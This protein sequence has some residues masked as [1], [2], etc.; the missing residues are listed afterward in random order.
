[1]KRHS[2]I[3]RENWRQRVEQIGFSFHTLDGVTYWDESAYYEFTRAEADKIEQ[4]TNEIYQLCLHAVDHVVKKGLYDLFLIPHPF[5]DKIELSWKNREPSVYGRFDLVWD[6]DEKSSPK[7]LEFNADTPTSLFE[8]AAVQWYWLS[9]IDSQKDQFNS[10]HEK[11]I[12]RWKELKNKIGDE[13]LYFSCLQQYPED[14]VNVN[15]LRDCAA[16]AEIQTQFISLQDIGRENGSFIDLEG[17]PIRWIFKLYPW[18]W[19]VNEEFSD[20]LLKFNTNWI[21]PIWKMILSNKAILPVLWK[22]FPGHP[23]LLESYFGDPHRLKSYAQKPLLSREGAN[24]IL[25]EDGKVISKTSGEYGEEGFIYQQLY[26]LPD[27]T[28]HRPVIGSWIIGE[29]SA[30]I[31]IRESKALVTDNFSRFVPHLIS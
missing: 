10:I 18:E 5:R 26:K 31:G 23:N 21:E 19:M 24:V 8:G 3:P 27:F 9:E 29:Q 12:G 30:G 17:K 1:M 4:S 2:I 20:S 16:Q 13:C 15:Y 28:N 7:M 25:I 22:L 14:V 6:G 11:L